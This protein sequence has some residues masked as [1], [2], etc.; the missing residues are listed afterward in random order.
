MH[1][2][3]L[4]MKLSSGADPGFMEGGFAKYLLAREARRN[5]GHA[6]FYRPRL[7][8]LNAPYYSSTSI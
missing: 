3:F 6:H 2:K 5:F 4:P 8:Y 1:F 7:F